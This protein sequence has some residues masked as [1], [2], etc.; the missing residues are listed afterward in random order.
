[1]LGKRLR[2]LERFRVCTFVA[3]LIK[4]TIVKVNEKR[5]TGTQVNSSDYHHHDDEN[6]KGD[7]QDIWKN[8]EMNTVAI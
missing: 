5:H 6:F 7:R 4:E 2:H 8:T 3:L 1:M